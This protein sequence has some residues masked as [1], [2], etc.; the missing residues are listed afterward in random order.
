MMS[1]RSFRPLTGNGIFNVIYMR[2]VIIESIRGA[3]SVPS[4]GTGFLIILLRQ[5]C[6][7]LATNS[8]RPLTGNGIFN[9]RKEVYIM[10]IR[11]KFPSP[12]GER[13]F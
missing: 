10:K 7:K 9:F 4:R 11:M 1:L 2:V 6:G 13:D 8:F 3:V 12:H 5:V